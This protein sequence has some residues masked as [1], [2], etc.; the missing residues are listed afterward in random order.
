[1]M[2]KNM[3]AIGI[4]I[5]LGL[6]LIFYLVATY[7]LDRRNLT[8]EV[9]KK[10]DTEITDKLTYEDE[11]NIV[12]NLYDEVR[13]LYDVVNNKFVVDQDNTIVIGE[14]VYKKITNFDE[15]TKNIFTSK[16]LEKYIN[17]LSNYFTYYD[18]NYYLIGNLV[19]YQTYYFRG[20]ETNIYILDATDGEI[21]AIIYERWTSNNK[22]TL[23][24]VKVV[25]E[26]NKWLIDKIDIL[27]T[28]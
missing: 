25:F 1:M 19:N 24:L 18:D 21:N 6:F 8:K 5:L 4:V 17:T 28:E 14:N 23:A 16:G 7:F 20:D 10:D 22:N 13:I 3:N 2:K 27:S 26:N 9:P 12:K 15:V 11:K